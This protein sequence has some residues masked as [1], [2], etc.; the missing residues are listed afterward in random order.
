MMRLGATS[1]QGTAVRYI[2]AAA[3]GG[4]GVYLI[5]SVFLN[6]AGGGGLGGQH[7]TCEMASPGSFSLIQIYKVDRYDRSFVRSLNDLNDP[8]EMGRWS[9]A[10]LY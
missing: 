10:C 9:Q 6:P 2:L 1:K 4:L 3:L 8:R 5:T 7:P